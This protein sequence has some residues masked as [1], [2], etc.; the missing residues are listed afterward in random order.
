M[1]DIKNCKIYIARLKDP[2][3]HGEVSFKDK[4]KE[5]SFTKYQIK[6]SDF[7]TK[8]A[9]ITMPHDIDLTLGLFV[10]NIVSIYHE[11]FMGFL[12]SKE[13]DEGTGLYTYQCQ[14][15]SRP[16]QSKFSARFNDVSVINI[17]RYCL[18]KGA[19]STGV[20]PTDNQRKEWSGYWKGLKNVNLY[21]QSLYKGNIVKGNPMKEK[22]NIT[23][24]GKSFMEAIRD[25]TFGRMTYIDLWFNDK[26]VL[27]FQPLSR[28][29]WYNTGLVLSAN[30]D[31]TFKFDT[32]NAITGGG[33][34][35]TNTKNDLGQAWATTI[36]RLDLSAFFGHIWTVV[37]AEVDSSTSNSTSKTNATSNSN[38]KVS[39]K[40]G[41]PF[42]NK[43]KNV[44][45]NADNGSG[46]K[47]NDLAKALKN[48]G[49]S[50]HIGATD[51]NA[52]YRDYWN[53][54]K[55]YSVYITLYNGFCAGTIREAYSSKIQNELKRKGVQ[56][57]P[58]WDSA[59]W[60]DPKGMKPYRYGDFSKYSAKRAWDDN[61]SSGDPSIKNV[62]D[63]FK[64][65]KA[66]YCVAPTTSEIMKQFNAGGY[67]KMKGLY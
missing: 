11:N 28:T 39:N 45:I 50:V 7:R 13:Y 1:F 64:K 10:V 61:F 17:L 16:L 29:D 23:I 5:R 2:T 54:T 8:T 67:A 63:F 59:G 12:L 51:S 49:W 57:V 53:V 65:N 62:G 42:N 20:D 14:D 32:T 36:T 55:D 48:A 26:G 56:L 43:K 25:L 24:K 38:S 44:W 37:D 15:W 52:H 33:A 3:S 40:Y 9:T 41:N 21:D 30:T 27:Q 22:I 35:I 6:E 47:K 58:I 60:T 18:T 19:Y 46:A 66:T 4:V 34:V 31:R